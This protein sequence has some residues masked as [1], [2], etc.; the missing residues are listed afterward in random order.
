MLEMLALTFVK[1]LANALL[2]GVWAYATGTDI[3]GAPSWFYKADKS[4]LCIY[5]FES[6][7]LEAVE[8]AKKKAGI[9]MIKKIDDLI[10]VVLYD[11]YKDLKDPKE[12]DFIQKLGKDD[13]LHLFVR[14]NMVFH[15]IKYDKDLKTAFVKA[16]IDNDVFLKY[17]KERSKKLA[18]ELTHYRADKNFDELEKEDM[19]LE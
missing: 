15:K 4:R 5:E 3:Q 17:Q 16:C 11:N 12:K 2:K 10:E 8:K 9:A 7:G 13:N 19:N 1:F 14:K 6:G 18:Y